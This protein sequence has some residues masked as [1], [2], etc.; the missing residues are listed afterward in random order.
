MIRD[1]SKKVSLAARSK[2]QLNSPT[3]GTT[4]PN[5]DA[6]MTPIPNLKL[7][8]KLCYCNE[9]VICHAPTL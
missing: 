4:S 1:P 6:G 3:S 7:N 5:P 8:V 9:T 2:E